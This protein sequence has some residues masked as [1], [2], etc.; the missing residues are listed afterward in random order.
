MVYFNFSFLSRE[1]I[2]LPILYLLYVYRSSIQ[3]MGDTILPAVSGIA[4]FI[5]RTCG[6]MILP[7]LLGATGIY[8]SEVLAWLGADLILIPSYVIT[9]RKQYKKM[10]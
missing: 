3:G 6:V 10:Q 2:C 5:M 4:E 9:L 7:V 1:S 8:L